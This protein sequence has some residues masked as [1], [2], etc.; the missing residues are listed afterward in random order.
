MYKA[1]NCTGIEP[2]KSIFSVISELPLLFLDLDGV[3]NSI[4]YWHK[5]GLTG[6]EILERPFDEEN[7]RCLNRVL[8]EVECQYVVTSA[9]RDFGFEDKHYICH[10]LSEAGVTQEPWAILDT[11]ER[12]M[13]RGIAIQTWLVNQGRDVAKQKLAILDDR[14]PK[15]FGWLNGYLVQTDIQTGMNDQDA[16]R[17]IAMLRGTDGRPGRFYG[18]TV[19]WHENEEE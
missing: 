12:F 16:L 7:V 8:N 18:Q 9:W 3:L 6:M 1:E 4:D 19:R 2:V 5:R 11:P 15:D 14:P 17:T 10:K 13:N